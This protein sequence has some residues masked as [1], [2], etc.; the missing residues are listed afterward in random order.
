M[1]PTT[2]AR[3]YEVIDRGIHIFLTTNP[4]GSAATGHWFLDWENKPL[5]FKIYRDLEAIP[6]PR[7]VRANDLPALQ[8]I[9]TPD[10]PRRCGMVR[11]FSIVTAMVCLM[12]FT[13]SFSSARR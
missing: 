3:T 7:S 12:K 1:A 9:A 2:V 13:I 5:P 10:E 6:L 11:R 8:A 4:A